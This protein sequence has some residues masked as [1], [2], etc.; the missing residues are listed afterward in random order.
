MA[1]RQGIQQD[2]RE[3]PRRAKA[4]A[5][6]PTSLDLALSLVT[7]PLVV[8]LVVAEQ[9][10]KWL[11]SLT[12]EDPGWWLGERLPNLDAATLQARLSPQEPPPPAPSPDPPVSSTFL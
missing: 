12:W 1:N 11:G 9:A 7:I 3:C 10:R 4:P 6:F 8:G 2:L 5:E